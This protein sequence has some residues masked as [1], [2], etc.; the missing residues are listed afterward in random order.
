VADAAARAKFPDWKHTANDGTVF[1][2]SVRKFKRNPIGLYDMHG[3][4]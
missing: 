4:P 2:S 1:T 3:N